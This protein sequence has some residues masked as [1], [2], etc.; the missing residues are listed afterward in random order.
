MLCA[1]C[2]DIIIFNPAASRQR[3]LIR[4]YANI[5]EL[6]ASHLHCDFCSFVYSEAH[7]L[8]SDYFRS[9]R[10]LWGENI[11]QEALSVSPIHIY[12]VDDPTAG[13]VTW[14]CEVPVSEVQGYSRGPTS[15]I[16]H[17]TLGDIFVDAGKQRG[18]LCIHIY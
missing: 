3:S 6:K 10:P 2:D 12:F 4:S 5:E 18:A 17:G 9:C 15:G 16:T 7:H 1:A 13:Y 11:Y 14:K 8:E